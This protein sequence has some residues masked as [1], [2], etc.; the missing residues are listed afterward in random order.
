MN[1]IRY[2]HRRNKQNLH[3][4]FV[5]VCIYADCLLYLDRSTTDP[6][7]ASG[8]RA[9]ARQQAAEAP[10]G[11]YPCYAQPAEQHCPH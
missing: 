4:C 8:H 11:I 3:L 6:V 5:S 10:D 2:V 9:R 7:R 1:I